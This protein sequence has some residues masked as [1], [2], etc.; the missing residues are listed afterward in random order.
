MYSID[1]FDTE[2]DWYT[3]E[4]KK[5]LKVFTKTFK[6]HPTLISHLNLLIHFYSY[7]VFVDSQF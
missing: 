3:N 4:M 6:N 2:D 1:W 5:Y 7:L